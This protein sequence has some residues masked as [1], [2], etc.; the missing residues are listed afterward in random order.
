MSAMASNLVLTH[1]SEH[2]DIGK[3]PS[4]AQHISNLLN[5]SNTPARPERKSKQVFR[6]P[7]QEYQFFSKY[8]QWREADKRRET[9]DEAVTRV[10][11]FF[12]DEIGVEKLTILEWNALHEGLLKLEG[13]PAMR[14]LQMAGPALKRCNV[15]AYNCS[16]ALTDS[17]FGFAE[18]LYILMQ[19]TGGGPAVPKVSVD[20]LPVI[21]HQ[22]KDSV[23]DSY[24]IGDSTEGWCDAL[25]IG[26]NT[27]YEGRDIIFD[28]S[29]VR[30]SGS[31]LKTKG[32]RSSG[33][34]PLR[35]LL[36]F[37]REKVLSRQGGKLT[38][39]DAHDI[40]CMIGQIVQV[41]GVRRAALIALFD[42]DDKEMSLCKQ[43]PEVQDHL[44]R[45]M[46]N[47]SAIFNHYPSWDEFSEL[48][49]VISE[50]GT[51]EPGIFN[52]Y[53]V[54]KS[55]PDRREMHEFITNACAEIVLRNRQFCNLSIAVA[56]AW[57][58]PETL[59]HKVYLA[60]VFG[61]LQSCLTRFSYIRPEYAQNCNE[62]RLLGVD[63]TGQ[64]DCPLL[65]PD[66]P[67]R[68]GLLQELRALV[69]DTNAE[70]AD[71]L[72]IPRSVATTC[73]KPGGNSAQLLG[74]C[75]GIHGWRSPYLIRRF[76]AGRTDPLSMMMISQG[77]PWQPVIGPN[78]T[79]ENSLVICFEFPVKAPEGA[80]TTEHL[81]EIQTLENWLV[82]K[83]EWAEHS[84]SQTVYVAHD[85]WEAVGKWVFDHWEQVTGL[86]FF[87]KSEAV[88]DLQPEEP[89]S[90][91]EYERLLSLF[92]EVDYNKLSNWELEDETIS[93]MSYACIGDKCEIM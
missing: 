87:P 65:R 51:G 68:T 61:T 35:M 29:Q 74:C 92:P 42:Y 30:P 49:K 48:W 1:S 4:P 17:L 7:T 58:T 84:V 6:L 31:R 15:G 24:I 36:D 91:Q 69:I 53:A 46:S 3:N 81:D 12:M 37:T 2:L 80:F 13:L 27:W 77:V 86:S 40:N 21:E 70:F 25:H 20:S 83:T 39:L 28:Y 85:K 78:E 60:T 76:R 11:D 64:M 62:E 44:Q 56:R 9:W 14:V 71:R 57:D 22:I 41:G 26:L 52:R 19:G 89:I 47:N 34:E 93:S 32:G 72:G 8:A 50:S 5:T 59:K 16:A 75:S 67:K 88:Y 73:V 66:N 18:L 90:Q 10:I 82:W 55:L 79:S 23:C 54:W 33:P 45:Y 38:T 43:Y 63:I